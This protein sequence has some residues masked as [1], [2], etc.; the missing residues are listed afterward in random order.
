MKNQI[1]QLLFFLINPFFLLIFRIALNQRKSKK[2]WLVD[3]DNTIAD[4]AN[5]YNSR[6]NFERLKN[7]TVLQGSQKLISEL[8]DTTIIFLT[9]R[10]YIYYFTTKKWLEKHNFLKNSFNLVLVLHPQQ[11]L[12]YL[13][14]IAYKYE[15]TFIDDLSF[16]QEINKLEFYSNLIEEIKKLP[17]IYYDYFY[18]K[19]LNSD[20][21]A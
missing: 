13:K 17:I 15:V 3:I 21:N 8:T 7:L 5:S 9:A 4:T 16:N 18:I 1:K 20:N 12:A 19:T 6:S 14:K 2:I 11:K 10:N